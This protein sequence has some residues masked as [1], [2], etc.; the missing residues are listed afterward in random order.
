MHDDASL[1][2]HRNGPLKAII[3]DSS[4]AH[5]DAVAASAPDDDCDM[6]AIRRVT[7]ALL[8]LGDQTTV[9]F[10]HRAPGQNMAP[11]ALLSNGR[12]TALIQR[13]QAAGLFNSALS[14]QW[15]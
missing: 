5:T 15:I 3:I 13:G 9:L 2:S 10:N 6:K 4:Q 11:T 8:S 1:L 7:N 12:L 14:P